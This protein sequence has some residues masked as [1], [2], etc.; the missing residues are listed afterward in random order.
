MDF[1][2]FKNPY[3]KS[4]REL[5][6]HREPFLF[7]DTIVSADE[8]GALGEYT[9][10]NEKNDF[11]RGHFPDYP[12]VPGVVLVEAMAQV[13]GAA[14]VAR[15]ILGGKDKEATFLLAAVDE[16]RFRRPVRPGDKFV[17]VVTNIK[18]G[19]RLGAFA[20]KGYVEGELAAEAKVKCILGEKDK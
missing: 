2:K 4:G 10:T 1:P 11:F 9:F 14:I 5:L 20:L 15:N 6:P 7:V 8:N 18:V 3:M 17:T 19:S 12:V 13:S 16:V